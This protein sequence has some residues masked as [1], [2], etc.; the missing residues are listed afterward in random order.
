MSLTSENHT[1]KEFL[2]DSVFDQGLFWSEKGIKAEQGKLNQEFEKALSGDLER[3]SDNPDQRAYLINLK[4]SI[5]RQLTRTRD[6]LAG[7]EGKPSNETFWSRNKER[8]L[9]FQSDLVERKLSEVET[10]IKRAIDS[11]IALRQVIEEAEK[12]NH[13]QKRKLNGLKNTIA[14]FE[15]IEKAAKEPINYEVQEGDT[16]S[17][18]GKKLGVDWK[19]ITYEN[20]KKP[21]P[22][23]LKVKARIVIKP[24]RKEDKTYDLSKKRK[25]NTALWK[26]TRELAKKSVEGISPG[27]WKVKEALRV[28]ND[29]GKFTGKRKKIGEVLTITEVKT[30]AQLANQKKIDATAF[31]S[32]GTE[33]V[34][35]KLDSGSWVALSYKDGK[36]LNVERKEVEDTIKGGRTIRVKQK[37]RVTPAGRLNEAGATEATLPGEEAVTLKGGEVIKVGAG[38][39][40][41]TKPS[42]LLA[43]RAAVPDGAAIKTPQAIK[44]MKRIRVEQGVILEPKEDNKSANIT[45]IRGIKRIKVR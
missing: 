18:I 26:E 14:A 16:L 5:D 23:K 32:A 20:G 8:A 15:K 38:D 10:A 45:G 11:R 44:G 36:T 42:D 9:E 35:G 1:Q 12:Q 19:T 43:E 33:R 22:R 2:I 6:W 25:E 7:S 21:N 13:E 37:A 39:A 30:G 40:K 29:N 28:R 3:H 31:L 41:I 34:W 17:N 24:P 4:T 27:E